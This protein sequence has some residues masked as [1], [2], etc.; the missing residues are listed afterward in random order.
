MGITVKEA[1][2]IEPLSRGKVISGYDGIDNMINR[3]SVIEASPG[4]LR[5]WLK[6]GE[7]FITSFY[8]S[9]K[10]TSDQMEC[11]RLMKENNSACLVIC[12]LG[13]WL[14]NISP[15][16]TKLSNELKIPLIIVPPEI[17]YA[18]IISSVMEVVL[19]IQNKKL[20]YALSLHKDLNRLIMKG[21]SIKDLHKMLYKKLGKGVIFFD[22]NM[23]S[24][25]PIPIGLRT[26]EADLEDE[27]RKNASQLYKNIDVLCDSLPKVSD[28]I[29][30]SPIVAEEMFYGVVCVVGAS[31]LEQ[32][33]HVAL[34]Q[35]KQAFAMIVIKQISIEEKKMQM[36][37]SIFSDLIEGNEI[38]DSEI[39][40]L[41][42]EFKLNLEQYKQVSVFEEILVTTNE[43]TDLDS[44]E[45][46][47]SLKLLVE[48]YFPDNFVF[49]YKNKVVMLIR[50]MEDTQEQR[51][52]LVYE[53]LENVTEE[54]EENNVNV[55]CG[56][57]EKAEGIFQLANSYNQSLI[58][59]DIGRKITKHKIIFYSQTGAYRFLAKLAKDEQAVAW[60]H[61]QLRLL[62]E[63]DQIHN[64]TFYETMKLLIEHNNDTKVVADLLYIHRN[65][66]LYWRRKIVEI[67][68]HEFYKDSFFAMN[69]RMAI[70][71][72]K[73]I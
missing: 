23:K 16:V 2:L 39:S 42:E 27:M 56:I 12:H 15:E 7:L 46:G 65:T 29:L 35:V 17:S 3:V 34:E 63:Y 61:S 60:A 22:S 68:G 19:D 67:I 53:L 26:K 58:A 54:W 5:P 9:A 52:Q 48:K 32:L 57:G 50:E 33:D 47:Q 43:E 13:G 4:S 59:L 40:W 24:V 72:E 70:E 25:S 8:N 44:G 45:K 49:A 38:S 71:I 31:S 73:L 30:F 21:A 1:M 14:K 55:I 51:E 28:H 6:G 37:L 11:V 36:F 10:S 62:K 41:K 66:L 20:D 69:Y 64:S 18:E